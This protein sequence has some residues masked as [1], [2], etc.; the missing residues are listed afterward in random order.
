MDKTT[1]DKINQACT[2]KYKGKDILVQTERDYVVR[3]FL[4]GY[5]QTVKKYEE[6]HGHTP[7]ETE[8]RTIIETLLNESSM[9]SYIASAKAYYNSYKTSIEDDYKR[10]LDKTS[11]WVNV[12]ISIVAN[13]IYSIF[14]II[15]FM[16]AKDQIATWLTQLS[17]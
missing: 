14:L 13:M 16:V 5:Y 17:S 4:E 10:K 6:T 12:G 15:V 1:Y 11:F 3:I 8:E 9:Q 7:T 2:T